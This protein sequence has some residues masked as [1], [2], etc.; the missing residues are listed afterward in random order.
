MKKRVVTLLLGVLM[1]LSMAVDRAE[2][3][4]IMTVSVVA[5]SSSGTGFNS[6]SLSPPLVNPASGSLASSAGVLGALGSL[7]FRD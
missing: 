3:S 4:T 5:T 1:L 6:V 2:A 7:S